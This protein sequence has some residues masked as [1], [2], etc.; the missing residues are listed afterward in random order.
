MLQ[1]HPSARTIPA[2]WAEIARSTGPSGVLA[3]RFGAPQPRQR[4]AHPQS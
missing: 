4:L 1:I 2:V 3:R